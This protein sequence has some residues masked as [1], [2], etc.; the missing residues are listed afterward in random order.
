MENCELTT[1]QQEIVTALQQSKNKNLITEA[2]LIKK[3]RENTKFQG[4]NKASLSLKDIEIAL[5]FLQKNEKLYFSIHCNSANNLFFKPEENPKEFEQSHRQRRLKSEQNLTLL[6]TSD[7]QTKKDSQQN[8]K[9][10]KKPHIK[11]TQ[12]TNLNIYGNY[13]EE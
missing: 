9:T 5:D 10:K 6:T 1:L 7:F 3:I 2:N 8:I 12:R 11:R 13:D 4:K